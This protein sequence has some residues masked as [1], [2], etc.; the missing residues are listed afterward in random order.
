MSNTETTENAPST[1]QCLCGN[2][3]YEV[4]GPLRSV[5]HC[6]CGQCRKTHGLMGPYT[7]A[8][9]SALVLINDTGLQ[10]YRSSDQAE[11]GFCN[12][13]GSSLFWRRIGDNQTGVERISISAGTLDQPT[14]LSVAGHI[15][16][17]DLAD[18]HTIPDDA[19]PKFQTTSSGNLDGDLST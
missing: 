17:E 3:A 15:Y 5:V 14:G 1:G 7:Q 10:W 19:L 11:R 6:Y 4:H 18:F 9:Q 13:C 8:E 16:T 12:R 2:V